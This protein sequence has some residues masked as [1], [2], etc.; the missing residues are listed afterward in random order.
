MANFITSKAFASIAKV[1]G[2]STLS[3]FP[4]SQVLDYAHPNRGWKASALISTSDNVVIDFGTATSI[5]AVVLDNL[6]STSIKVQGNATDSWGAPSHSTTVAVSQ[7][8]ADLRY[9]VYAA[10]TSFNYRYMR[11]LNNTSSAAD[12]QAVLQ[13]GAII[14]LTSVDTWDTNAGWPYEVEPMQDVARHE[15]GDPE[16]VALSNRY[17]LIKLTQAVVPVSAEATFTT[18]IGYGEAQPFV[19]FRNNGRSQEVYVV[20][21]VGKVGWGQAGPNHFTMPSMTLEEVR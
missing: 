13:I 2:S 6:N 18:I 4:A 1:T 11:I 14:P 19:F 7:D 5:P 16:T 21:R 12:G 17:A 10:L 8:T 15:F 20:R 3:G 9:K